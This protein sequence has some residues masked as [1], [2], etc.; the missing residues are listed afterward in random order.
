MT[1]CIRRNPV[2][3]R[4]YNGRVRHAKLSLTGISY[5]TAGSDR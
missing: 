4:K 2:L 1:A 5:C 3:V